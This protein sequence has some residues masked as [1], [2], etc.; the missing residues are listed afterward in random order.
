MPVLVLKDSKSLFIGEDKFYKDQPTKIED[1]IAY[2]RYVFKGDFEEFP[3]QGTY[4]LESTSEKPYTCY[5][6]GGLQRFPFGVVRRISRRVYSKL[7]PLASLRRVTVAE[8]LTRDALADLAIGHCSP[9]TVSVLVTRDM[10]AGDVVI[11]TDVVHHLKR[12]FPHVDVHFQTGRRY[13]SLLYGHPDL[14]GVHVIGEVN[15]FEFTYDVNLVRRS[16]VIP[17]ASYKVRVDMYLEE[18]GLTSKE[19]RTC[20]ILSDQDKIDAETTL[21]SHGFDPL[22]HRLR[23]VLQPSGSGYHRS[24]SLSAR[25]Q[26]AVLA[27]DAGWDVVVY[28]N[29]EDHFPDPF[30]GV[31]NLCGKLADLRQVAAVISRCDFWVGPDSAGYHIAAALDPPVDALV[32]FTTIPPY[33]RLRD[34]PRCWA[35][36]PEGLNCFPCIDRPTCGGAYHC[37]GELTGER[38]FDRIQKIVSGS[39]PREI[40]VISGNV[41]VS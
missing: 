3:T 36:T 15:P 12:E 38:I 19:H 35:I 9:I 26:L 40:S 37:V 10:G 17:D 21:R 11:A 32:C 8:A 27:C 22:R 39:F 28:G 23:L 31:V 29:S 6:D 18:I 41:V 20:V 4:L 33:L 7:P 1:E 16:E 30:E 2:S 5:V 24:L 14:S 25:R 34:Y 13:A